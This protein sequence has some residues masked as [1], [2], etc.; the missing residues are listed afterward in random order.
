M[1][2]ISGKKWNIFI[3]WLLIKTVWKLRRPC[4]TDLN[5]WHLMKDTGDDEYTQ[6]IPVTLLPHPKFS[7][8]S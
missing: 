6:Q 8:P 4:R 3:K 2:P 1:I 5:P 7:A